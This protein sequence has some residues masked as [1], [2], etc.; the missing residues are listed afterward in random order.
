MRISYGFVLL[1]MAG[2]NVHAA[3]LYKCTGPKKNA[4]SIQSAPCPAGSRQI[5]VRDGTPEPPLTDRQMAAQ[6]AKRQ[7][8][9]EAA[10]TLSDMAGTSQRNTVVVYQTGSSNDYRKQR[11]DSAKRQA[12]Q[13]RDRDWRRLTVDRLR[14]LDAWVE[15]ECK[16]T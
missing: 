9:A 1:L 7:H 5:W 13:I 2:S 4:V 10:R 12:K 3:A 14:Q 16:N 8:D 15:A 11:C 6:N